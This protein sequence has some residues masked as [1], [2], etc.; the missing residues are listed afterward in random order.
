METGNSYAEILTEFNITSVEWL[1]L[2]TITY[3]VPYDH[4]IDEL[5]GEA[6]AIGENISEKEVSAV[7]AACFEKGWIQIITDE[8]LFE[9][10][11][12]VNQCEE[13]GPVCGFPELGEVDFTIVGAHLFNAVQDR[14]H[15][16]DFDIDDAWETIEN[17]VHQHYFRTRKAALQYKDEL[18]R[19]PNTVAISGP[20]DIG[21]WCVYWWK[22]FSEGYRLDEIRSEE[23]PDG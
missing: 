14:V 11:R 21:P 19:D 22:H 17:G 18:L 9:I 2:G 23:T 4:I 12:T 3:Y 20:F 5:I 13:I 1:V 7:F 15:G 10:E 16:P 6:L 8:A